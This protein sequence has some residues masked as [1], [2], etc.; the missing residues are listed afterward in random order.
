MYEEVFQKI[1]AFTSLK[2]IAFYLISIKEILKSAPEIKKF[3]DDKIKQLWGLKHIGFPVSAAQAE[4]FRKLADSNVYSSV[5]ACL[6]GH[7][8]IEPTL[9]GLYVDKLNKENRRSEIT[10][11][12]N[13][14]HKKY[15][16]DGIRIIDLATTGAI[17]PVLW[18]LTDLKQRKNYCATDL[19]I[20]FSKILENWKNI[21]I[22]VEKE[23]L[24]K[25]VEDKIV[26]YMVQEK[27]IFFVFS[28]G[29][30]A[31]KPAISAIAKLN[32]NGSFQ[33]GKYVFFSHPE[34]EGDVE[35]Y[36]WVIETTNLIQAP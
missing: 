24:Q 36:M 3:A 22:F 13:K 27:P 32:N 31:S 34:I 2:E 19:A 5:K 10:E 20:E 18:Y 17:I 8:A 33:K 12:R 7:W 4:E 21:S 29:Q 26:H 35:K 25:E 23:T 15:G 14:V 6:T 28:Y 16:L 11:I 30:V 9:S 1:A